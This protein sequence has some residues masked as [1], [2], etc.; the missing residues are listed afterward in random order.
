MEKIIR[1]IRDEQ[2]LKVKART[3]FLKLT[4]SVKFESQ[5]QNLS[6]QLKPNIYPSEEKKL[7]EKNLNFANLRSK[8]HVKPSHL[9][10]L[11]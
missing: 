9:Y 8:M 7:F 3:V 10:Q 6:L 5:T 2:I 11:S 1:M 4:P